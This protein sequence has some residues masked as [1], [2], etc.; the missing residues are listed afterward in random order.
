MSTAGHLTHPSELGTLEEPSWLR[1]ELVEPV[2]VVDVDPRLRDLPVADVHDDH[3]VKFPRG[4]HP[5][6]RLDPPTALVRLAG[7]GR[8]R[9]PSNESSDGNDRHDVGNHPNELLRE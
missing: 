9:H 8:R 3:I 7:R 2:L 6:L 5:P 4:R 1:E